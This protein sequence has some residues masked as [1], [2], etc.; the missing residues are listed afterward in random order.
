MKEYK[1][2]SE[3][4]D[5]LIS[6]N[7]II[8]NRERAE[9]LVE[10][11]S[12]YSIV[13]TYKYV[14]KDEENN[15]KPNVTFEEIFSLYEFDKNI[16]AIFL[17]FT[18]EIEVIIKSLIAN[19][20]SEKYGIKNYLKINNFDENAD[21]KFIKELIN[22]IN[23]TIKDNNTK[24]LAINHYMSNYN[25]IPPYVLMKVLSFGTVS[26]YYGLLKQSDRQKISKYFRLPDN[27]LKQILINLTMIRNISAHSDR[28]FS[29]RSKSYISFKYIDENYMGK[30]D[31]TNLYIIFKSMMILLD[32]DKYNEF[33]NSFNKEIKKLEKNLKSIEVHDV[34]KIMGFST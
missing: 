11:Y 17:K 26:R 24:H 8:E 4:I 10:R 13:N 23:K 32:N 30:N 25:F 14:F 21:E 18:L 2:N 7:V 1:T 20:I 19:I 15:Y 33:E 22:S 27:I 3:L 5:Y 9:K 34:L 16:K 6:K 31:F 12:Y 29:F 28:L